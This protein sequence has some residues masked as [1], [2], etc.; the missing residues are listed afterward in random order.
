ML[1]KEYLQVTTEA[2]HVAEETGYNFNQ[3]G[4]VLWFGCLFFFFV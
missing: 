4:F 1:Q 2:F 3:D